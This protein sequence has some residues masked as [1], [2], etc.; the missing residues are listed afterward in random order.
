MPL[1]KQ[2]CIGR[3]AEQG[4]RYGQNG[5]DAGGAERGVAAGAEDCVDKAADE[6]FLE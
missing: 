2:N 5:Q 1:M 6:P 4:E 3:A